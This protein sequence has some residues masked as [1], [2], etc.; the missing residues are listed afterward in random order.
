MFSPKQNQDSE[1]TGERQTLL[2][3]HAKVTIK[4]VDVNPENITVLQVREWMFDAVP[5]IELIFTDQGV[6]F[7]KYPLEESDILT[8]ELGVTRESEPVIVAN[9]KCLDYEVIPFVTGDSLGGSAVRITGVL[10]NTDFFAPKKSRSFREVTSTDVIT[11]IAGESGFEADIRTETN[12]TMT[13]IQ[14]HQ[15]NN[16]MIGHL[17]ARMYKNDNDCL[18]CSTNR[19]GTMV[20]TSLQDAIAEEPKFVGVFQVR[21]T[22]KLDEA[23]DLDDYKVLDDSEVIYYSG[24]RYV[25]M[26]GTLNRKIGYGQFTEYYDGTDPQIAES[27]SDIHSLTTGSNKLKELVETEAAHV[28]AGLQ[29]V[30][31]HTNYIKAMSNNKY[32]KSE[33]CSSYLKITSKPNSEVNVFDKVD[34]AVPSQDGNFTD[35]THSGEYMIGGIVHNISNK[36]LYT[37]DL[38]LFRNGKNI[39][40][41][42]DDEAVSM[43]S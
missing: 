43:L 1:G 7:D 4:E 2:H 21:E 41:G 12:D 20:V 40:M 26:G 36:G 9:F 32:V 31:M 3:Y 38:Y 5:R 23:T 28:V 35:G 10:D 15:N 24:Y 11:E 34:L 25:N 8:L 30:N 19:A 27:V 22:A 18:F 33:F 6:F 13:W 16:E 39:D 37:T 42:Y 29:S 14:A 17:L